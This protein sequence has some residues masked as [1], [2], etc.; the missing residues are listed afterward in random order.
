MMW[1]ADFRICGA[2][3]ASR[4]HVMKAERS[5]LGAISSPW[6]RLK[7][8]RTQPVHA[9]GSIGRSKCDCGGWKRYGP[10]SLPGS[11]SSTA[12]YWLRMGVT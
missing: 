7:R 3:V 6:W 9:D 12:V 2:S 8:R 1:A 11:S 10:S 4:S 5:V